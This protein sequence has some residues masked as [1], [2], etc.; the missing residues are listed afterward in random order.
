MST[1]G[2][3]TC[4]FGPT[5]HKGEGNVF[6]HPTVSLGGLIVWPRR[7][8]PPIGNTISTPHSAPIMQLLLE[9][10]KILSSSDSSVTLHSA[11]KAGSYA[12][13]V[14]VLH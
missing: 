1:H 8:W 9:H 14:Q 10:G 3:G 7:G 11:P 4:C 2:T 6:G 13:T 12:T 5:A